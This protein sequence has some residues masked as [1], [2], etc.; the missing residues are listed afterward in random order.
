MFELKWFFWLCS[1]VAVTFAFF[2]ILAPWLF[3][4]PPA[5]DSEQGRIIMEQLRCRFENGGDVSSC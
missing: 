4:G 2:L 1:I 5:V 3:P